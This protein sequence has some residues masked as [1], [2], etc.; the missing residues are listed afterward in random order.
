MAAL[1]AVLV[2]FLKAS[3]GGK[4]VLL[5]K[6]NSFGL[7]GIVGY[8]VSVEID[9]SGGLPAFELV[10]LPDAAVKEARERVRSALKNSGYEY[11]TQRITVN[12]APADMKKE[13]PLYDLPMAVGMLAAMETLPKEKAEP[14]CMLG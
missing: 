9:I 11:P 5:S 10:G 7:L 6:I 8:P 3:K 4:L 13:G 14:F 2:V 1:D 12:L